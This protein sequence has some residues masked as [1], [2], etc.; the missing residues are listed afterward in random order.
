MCSGVKTASLLYE[1]HGNMFYTGVGIGAERLLHET[2]FVVHDTHKQVP[3]AAMLVTA[4]TA[5]LRQLSG[6][7]NCS[8]GR[9]PN[10]KINGTRDLATINGTLAAHLEYAIGNRSEVLV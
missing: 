5:L 2:G 10:S 4:K 7:L 6:W 9:Y 3:S 8:R 1:D